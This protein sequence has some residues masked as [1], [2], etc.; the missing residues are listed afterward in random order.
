[1]TG[2]SKTMERGDD[3]TSQNRAD[4]RGARGECSPHGEKRLRPHLTTSVTQPRLF[5]LA[6]AREY[7]IWE[8][9]SNAPARLGGQIDRRL[10]NPRADQSPINETEFTHPTRHP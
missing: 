1:M 6:R 7:Q 5:R 4:R 3:S 9:E 2:S 10:I 8:V